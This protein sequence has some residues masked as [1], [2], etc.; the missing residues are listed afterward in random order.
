MSPSA[1]ERE[2]NVRQLPSEKQILS[3]LRLAAAD[4]TF[5][6]SGRFSQLAGSLS[7]MKSFAANKSGNVRSQTNVGSNGKWS[8]GV[9]HANYLQE[10]IEHVGTGSIYE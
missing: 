10:R 1:P 4:G 8:T 3:E 5:A 6:L 9:E 2:K 7:R